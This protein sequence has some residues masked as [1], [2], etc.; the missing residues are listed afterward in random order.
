MGER[1]RNRCAGCARS[2]GHVPH[3]AR[4]VAHAKQV[5]KAP[6]KAAKR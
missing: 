1:S 6:A 4:I 5:E 2:S 3:L